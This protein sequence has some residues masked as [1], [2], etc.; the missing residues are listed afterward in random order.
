MII[1]AALPDGWDNVAMTM[2]HSGTS[3]KLSLD[4]IVPKLHEEWERHHSRGSHNVNVARSNIRIGGGKPQW[5]TPYPNRN[6]QNFDRQE[7]SSRRPYDNRPLQNRIGNSA[8]Q[9][10][11]F[12][13]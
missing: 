3:D 12:N 11:K 4:N 5:K 8:P 13:K 6:Q 10:N 7:G 9:Q 2:L 1:L